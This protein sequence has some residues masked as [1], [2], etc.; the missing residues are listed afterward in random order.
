MEH[1]VGNDGD[2]GDEEEVVEIIARLFGVPHW[3]GQMV[4]QKIFGV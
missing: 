4:H 1:E 3:V 2:D